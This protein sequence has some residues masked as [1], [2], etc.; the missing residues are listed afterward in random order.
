MTNATTPKIFI[1]SEIIP[2]INNGSI[3]TYRSLMGPD[4]LVEL[5]K[6]ASTFVKVN[7]STESINRKVVV[8]I[9]TITAVDMYED[10][11]SATVYTN[12]NGVFPTKE[13]YEDMKKIFLLSKESV[14]TNRTVVTSN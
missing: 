9:V 3:R 6:Q 7:G 11:Y 2:L 12:S 5:T 8:N 10:G 4:T 1:V 14:V 13:S